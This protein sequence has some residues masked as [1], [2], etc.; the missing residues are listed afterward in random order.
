MNEYKILNELAQTEGTVIFG[1]T[2]DLNIP[3]CEIKQAFSIS[4]NLYN[5]SVKDL[6]VTDSVEIYSKYISEICPKTLFVHIGKSDMEMFSSFSDEFTKK[7]RELI[8]YIKNDNKNCKIA[9]VSLEN[10]DD[11]AIAN[12]MNKQLKYIAES[13]NCE[14]CDISEKRV[15]DYRQTKEI[16]SFVYDIGFVRRLKCARPLGDLAQMLFCFR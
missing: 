13:E 8:S 7:Y 15:S 14:F 1:G 9:V 16:V 2:E 5:R 12:K 6:S 4:E 3:L 10:Y 11:N